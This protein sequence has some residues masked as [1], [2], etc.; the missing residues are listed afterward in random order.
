MNADNKVTIEN[1]LAF[2]RKEYI[3]QRI[4]DAHFEYWRG[5]FFG[6]VGP[7]TL[8]SY[9]C[10][11]LRSG[12][13]GLDILRYEA[14][15]F[16]NLY[17]P[18]N[19][20]RGKTRE[21]VLHELPGGRI[22]KQAVQSLPWPEVANWYLNGLWS[23]NSDANVIG[24]FDSTYE[25]TDC[26]TGLPVQPVVWSTSTLKFIKR[27]PVHVGG[28]PERADLRAK[29]WGGATIDAALVN[30]IW[31]GRGEFT[32]VMAARVREACQLAGWPCTL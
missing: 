17:G 18:P 21:G 3:F 7:A 31:A 8:A 26:I 25:C 24:L 6:C 4:D 13:F 15:T 28:A 22:N 10:P 23:Y 1:I 5:P 20:K 32:E 30:E 14:D 11:W 16:V 29:V 9:A 2:C 27:K 19:L 12:R